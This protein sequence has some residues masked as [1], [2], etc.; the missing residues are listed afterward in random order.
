MFPT[1]LSNKDKVIEIY[2]KK[3]E[4]TLNRSLKRLKEKGL[5]P[6]LPTNPTRKSIVIQGCD[7]KPVIAF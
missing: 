6:V 4:K 5:K 1:D 3:I 7:K 2:E